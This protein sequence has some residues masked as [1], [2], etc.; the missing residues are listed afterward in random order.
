M[1]IVARVEG[2]GEEFY[3]TRQSCPQCGAG[4]PV[5][6]PRLFTWSQKF[7]SCPVCE[8]SGLAWAE[9]EDNGEPAM[10]GLRR[11]AAAPRALAIG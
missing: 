11:H 4:L 9:S 1:M 10:P 7:G 8:G 5:P 2:E 3:S 6:D